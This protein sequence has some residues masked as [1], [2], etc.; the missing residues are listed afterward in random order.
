MKTKV[1][2][3]ECT[4]KFKDISKDF[5]NNKTN[6]SF[7]VNENI[8]AEYDKIKDCEKLSIK[9]IKYRKKRSLD[10]NAYAWTLI[11]KIAVV[12][13][14]DKDTV[15]ELMLQ[16]Y[17]QSYLDE[18]GISEKISVLSNID[19]SKLHIHTKLIG[20]SYIEDKEFA[21]YILIKGSSEYDT[22][23]MADFIDGIV[24]DAKELEIETL[25]PNEIERMKSQWGV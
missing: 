17:G 6:I 1:N 2:W 3:M 23:E 15:Y 24:S 18:N 9:V 8:L 25:T 4:G 11:S 14:S 22:K 21:H 10:A 19:L 20:K 5:S 16:K 13:K 12:V 7:S